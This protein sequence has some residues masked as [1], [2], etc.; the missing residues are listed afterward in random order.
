M[1]LTKKQRER[2]ILADKLGLKR[3]DLRE[4]GALSRLESN[5]KRAQSRL[6]K[7]VYGTSVSTLTPSQKG[8]IT[9]ALKARNSEKELPKRGYLKVGKSN[10]DRR[11]NNPDRLVIN[12]NIYVKKA[13]KN[14]K[15][16]VSKKGVVSYVSPLAQTLSITVP[17]PTVGT[18]LA[19]ESEGNGAISDYYADTVAFA[20]SKG[21][22]VFLGYSLLSHFHTIDDINTVARIIS[23]LVNKKINE[24]QNLDE[25]DPLDLTGIKELS[26]I[27]HFEK[28]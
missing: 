15:A 2:V 10:P 6:S 9:K 8:A 4:R 24:I 3:L 19:I 25:N 22:P 16:T 13:Y 28:T 11:T 18:M 14:L 7:Q 17:I 1:A 12:G 27:L 5:I 26:I 21:Y 23:S 20:R